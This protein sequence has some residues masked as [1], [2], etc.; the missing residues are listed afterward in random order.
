[1]PWVFAGL[2]MLLL[3]GVTIAIVS[4]SGTKPL[5]AGQSQQGASKDESSTA[6]PTPVTTEQSTPAPDDSEITTTTD[7]SG[8]DIKTRIFKSNQRVA[9]VVVTTRDGKQTARV[10]STQGEERDLPPDKVATALNVP[11][12]LLADEVGFIKEK[13]TA[14]DQKIASQKSVAPVKSPDRRTTA[15]AKPSSSTTGGAVIDRAMNGQA[16]RQDNSP[17]NAQQKTSSPKTQINQVSNK[18]ATQPRAVNSKD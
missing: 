6:A 1:M 15:G 2:A 9:Q 3:V 18:S 17:A 13:G 14:S 12:D 5:A 7:A 10:S 8:A 16:N 4:N 11:G